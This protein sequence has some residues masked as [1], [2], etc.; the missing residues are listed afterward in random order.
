MALDFEKYKS[1]CTH[2]R[3]RVDALGYR[4]ED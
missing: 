4:V 3:L 2:M 1:R